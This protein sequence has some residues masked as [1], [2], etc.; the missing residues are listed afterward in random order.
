M[1]N[2]RYCVAA[3]VRQLE[4]ERLVHADVRQLDREPIIPL[5]RRNVQRLWL[6]RPFPPLMGL[7]LKISGQGGRLVRLMQPEP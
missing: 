1:S 2:I 6:R 7:A 4:A 5:R 3:Q